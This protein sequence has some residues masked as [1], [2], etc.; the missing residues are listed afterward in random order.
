VL[1]GFRGILAMKRNLAGEAIPHFKKVLSLKPNQTAAWLYLGQAYFRREKYREALDALVR[2][3]KIGQK[4]PSY[5]QLLARVEKALGR[6][7]DSYDTLERALRRFPNEHELLREEALLLVNAGL[8][9]AALEKGQEYLARRPEDRNG[10]LILG[11]ALRSAGRPREAAV[12]LEWAVL[13]FNQDPEV[14][15]RLA[16][17]YATDRRWLA[18]ARLFTRST[19]LGGDF[20]HEAAEHF[21]L[22]GKL[23]EA[24]EQ[25]ALVQNLEKRLRQRLA[26]YIEAERFARA[27]AL[28]RLL[29]AA[30]ALDDTTRYRLAY[31]HLR[32]G[33]LDRAKDLCLQVKDPAIEE[34]TAKILEAVAE[35][36]GLEGPAPREMSPHPTQP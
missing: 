32:T 31:A 14:L 29:V 23:R 34:S 6:P 24:L 2:G 15:A 16:F 27:A 12:I 4:I 10:Y 17:S 18:A 22:A 35:H 1:E 25:N 36:Q 8:Y 28:D 5:F 19:R 20:A 33:N 30:Q 13:R 9:L 3:D 11:E 7:Q 21:R 26:L